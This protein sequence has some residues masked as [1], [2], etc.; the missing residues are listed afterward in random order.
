MNFLAHIAMTKVRLNA[1]KKYVDTGD[2]NRCKEI[3][4]SKAET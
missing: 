2:I 1:L 3:E 4:I